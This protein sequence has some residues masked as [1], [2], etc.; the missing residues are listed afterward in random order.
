MVMPRWTTCKPL[1]VV[2]SSCQDLFYS[3]IDVYD[4]YLLTMMKTYNAEVYE[5]T[6][7]R[8]FTNMTRVPYCSQSH[9]ARHEEANK[10][11]QNMFPGNSLDELD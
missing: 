7:S 2:Q 10:R 8:L 11:A 6:Q 1:E 3:I 9:N 4:D 5:H